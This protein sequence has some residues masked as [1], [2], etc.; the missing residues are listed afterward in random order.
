MRFGPAEYLGTAPG[1]EHLP[2]GQ[3]HLQTYHLG[4]HGAVAGSQVAHAVGGY[5]AGDG[6]DGHAPGVV[7]QGQAVVL[8]HPPQVLQD[9][10][11][12]GDHGEVRGVDLQDPVEAL[13]VNHDPSL[14]GNRRTHD[15][16]TASIGD[17]GDPV[18]RGQPDDIYYLLEA[19]WHHHQVGDAVEE[20]R[21]L[22]GAVRG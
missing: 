1:S 18:L 21:G 5:C 10:S 8:E 2:S 19:A 16:G 4:A 14:D 12:L 9:H 22:E 3:H 13:Q 7:A 20:R 17:D 15:A 6:G 11:R